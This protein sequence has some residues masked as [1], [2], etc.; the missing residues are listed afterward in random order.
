MLP[1]SKLCC[2]ALGALICSDNSWCNDA[3]L[4]EALPPKCH[5]VTVLVI[6]AAIELLLN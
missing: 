3:E 2:Q 1:N 6:A 5:Q 4:I